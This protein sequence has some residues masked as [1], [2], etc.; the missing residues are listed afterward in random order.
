M[1]KR[2]GIKQWKSKSHYKLYTRLIKE[3]KVPENQTFQ[4]SC[5]LTNLPHLP[6]QVNIEVY[7]KLRVIQKY[8]IY[9]KFEHI[10]LYII[11]HYWGFRVFD[12]RTIKLVLWDSLISFRRYIKEYLLEIL[13]NQYP[14][15]YTFC[16]I[17]FISMNIMD[18]QCCH[19]ITGQ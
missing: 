13:F 15:H 2:K 9:Y 18:Y 10:C 4:R 5:T 14:L 1:M 6:C 19:Y 3:V 11:E 16:A 8:I 12:D 17:H 7:L